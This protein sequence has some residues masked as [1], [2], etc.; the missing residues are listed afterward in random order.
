MN[1]N[2]KYN[3][4][5]KILVDKWKST[6][7]VYIKRKIENKL[8]KVNIKLIKGYVFSFSQNFSILD[9][10]NQIAYLSIIKALQSFD[11]TRGTSFNYWWAYFVH[12]TLSEY[13]RFG[14]RT[15]KTNPEYTSTKN[16]DEYGADVEE[17]PLYSFEEMIECNTLDDRERFVIIMYYKNNLTFSEIASR[18]NRS[19]Q[20]SCNIRNTALAKIKKY[21]NTNTK[22]GYY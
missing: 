11:N 10:L 2:K 21:I 13:V 6:N 3:I 19:K 15:I 12:S 22:L 20:R 7:D 5:N 8:I 17:K 18:I 9:D 4:I 1:D 16:L 14:N